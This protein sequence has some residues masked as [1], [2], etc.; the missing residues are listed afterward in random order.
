VA[1]AQ[2]FAPWQQATIEI[3]LA[4]SLT[5]AC[6]RKI[7][8]GVILHAHP[9]RDESHINT[10]PPERLQQHPLLFTTNHTDRMFF[11]PRLNSA[12]PPHPGHSTILLQLETRVACAQSFTPWQQA[13]IEIIFAISL[14]IACSHYIYYGVILRAHPVRDESH[15]QRN[16]TR[17]VATLQC[18]KK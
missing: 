18:N 17:E 15:N 8:Y 2:S 6:S 7:Y 16:A 13:T 5:I 3:M 14:T 11:V 9:V 12:R 1:C 10:T 4:I